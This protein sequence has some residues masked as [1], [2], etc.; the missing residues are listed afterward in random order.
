M[1]IFRRLYPLISSRAVFVAAL[2]A[3]LVLLMLV[4]GELIVRLAVP[5]PSPRP[6]LAL[7]TPAEAAQ[8]VVSRHLFGRGDPASVA[9]RPVDGAAVRV[10]GVA[11]SGPSGGGFAILSVDGKPPVPAVDGQE[12]APGLRLKR[13]TAAGIEYERTDRP[14]AS[15]YAGLQRPAAADAPAAGNEPAKPPSN[16]ASAALR[17]RAMGR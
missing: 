10:L 9:G 8:A 2:G 13:V 15:L 11:S 16:P 17:P 7:P 5:R 3:S 1:P 6:V 14:G 12:F 4:L